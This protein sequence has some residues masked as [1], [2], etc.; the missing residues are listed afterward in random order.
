M[1]EDISDFNGHDSPLLYGKGS[2][3]GGGGGGGEG[4]FYLSHAGDS[5]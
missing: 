4:D 1:G 2:E 5:Y 3:G